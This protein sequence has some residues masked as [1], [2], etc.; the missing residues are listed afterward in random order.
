MA[1]SGMKFFYHQILGWNE[2]QLFIP[3]RKRSWQ[4]P[5]VLGQKE[6]ERLLSAAVKP[7]RLLKNS[8]F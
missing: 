5:E 4:L 1:I 6:V 8:E 3:P 7:S 2:K